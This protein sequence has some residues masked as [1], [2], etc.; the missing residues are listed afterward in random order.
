VEDRE[1]DALGDVLGDHLTPR[2][3]AQHR[4]RLQRRNG[5]DERMRIRNSGN[6]ASS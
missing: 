5:R 6:C 2:R 1:A 4:V 3:I